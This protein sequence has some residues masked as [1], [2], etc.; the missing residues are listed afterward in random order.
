MQELRANT[1]IIVTV[2]PFVDVGDGFTPQT[3]IALAGNEAELLKHGSTT[4]VDIS[5]ATWAA[6]ANCRGYYS[7]TLTTSHTNTE[8]LLVVIVQ[9][10]SDCLPVKQEYMVLSEAAWD[11]KYVAKDDGFMD[12][13]IKTV[14]RAD[15][16]ETEANNLESACSNYSATRGLTGTAVP[17]AV[18][19]AAGGVPISDAGGLDLDD[20]PKRLDRNAD[21]VESQRGSHT[22]QGDY[23]YVDPVN[24][25]THANGNRG[26]R[27]DPYKTIQDCHDNAITDNNH[28]VIFLV[29]GAASGATT[30]TI[31]ATTTISKNYVFLRGPG[32]NFIITRTGS[33]DTL[34]IT[35]DGVELGGT[36]IGTAATGSG[37]GVDITDADF[38]RIHHCWFLDTQGD[39]VR[40]LRGSNCQIHGNDFDGTGVGG[41]GQGIHIVGTAG[42]S[43]GN[44]IFD[45]EMHGT[46]G[47]AILIE[48]GTTNDTLIYGNDIHDAGGWG[49]NIGAS[50]TR[51][52]VYDN[53]LGNNSSGDINDG[54]SD[55]IEKHN[56]DWL[57]STTESRT[58]DVTSTGAAGVDWANVEN[59]TTAVDLSATDIQL[60]DTVTTLTQTKTG[61]ANGAVWI[62]TNASNT[63]TA[64]YVDG[65][66]DNPVSTIAAATTIA[67]NVNIKKFVLVSGSSI[68]LAQAYDNYIFDACH[69]TIALGG[70]SINNTVFIGAVITGNDDGSNANYVQY[71]DCVI[72]TNTLGQFVMTR[73]YFT[74][75]L[76]LAQAGSY[77]LHQCFSGVAGTSTP[78]LNFGSGLNASNVNMRDYSG[79]IEIQ[80]M[81]KGTGNYNMSLEGNGQLVINANSTADGGGT[82]TVAIRGNFT[83]TDNAGGA[84]TLSD[85]ARI[86]VAQINSEADTALSDYNPPTKAEMDTAHALL[87]TPAQVNTQCDT[88]L[89]DY[90]GPTKGQMDTAHGLLATVAKQDV[91]KVVTDALTAAAAAK[92]ALSA[93]TMVTGTV[94]WDNTNATT[95]IFYAD[96]ITEATGDHFIGRRVYPTSGALVGQ[97]TEITDYAL[98]SGEG[99]F[100]V[101]ALTEPPADNVT[102]IIV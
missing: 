88:A 80:N 85:D 17:A 16:Q 60:C 76:T 100:T 47:D 39:G 13:N 45:N 26:G 41:S 30:H 46:G 31:A 50:S 18:A 81:G 4:V 97:A 72:G 90:A 69:S 64:S 49:I 14:G 73:C 37:D 11:S 65:T 55:T 92:M 102:F 84:V 34:A 98:V 36:R 43:N 83:V 74:A 82:S 33:G 38:A 95:T 23:Y 9:D 35:G 66:A 77:F 29:S 89:T 51:A 12:V 101:A 32:R 59:P 27:A 15:T 2:G 79:G 62:D 20:L 25:D 67:G 63:N 96:D 3:D 58:L 7:L 48:G 44:S 6:V 52:V 19:D 42:S 86:D 78:S 93:G 70:Q 94:S 28:D 24:G 71:F 99:Q 56:R 8:G 68:T 91:I 1:Q 40:I 87:A 21:L 54:G 57:S 22:W 53:N 5:G 75:T 10:D 61:Y